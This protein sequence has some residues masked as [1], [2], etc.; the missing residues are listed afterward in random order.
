MP[1]KKNT[2][3]GFWARVLKTDNCWLW[4]GAKQARGYGFVKYHGRQHG[5]HRIAWQL[6]NGPIPDG[7][8]VCHHCDNPQCVRPEHLFIGTTSDNMIDCSRKGRLVDN[9]G[10]NQGRSRLTEIDVVEIRTMDKCGISQREIA[11]KYSVS[12]PL[13]SM[14]LSRKTWRHI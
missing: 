13:I 10:A 2:P 9:S 11:S 8:S 14:I 3:E 7:M 12:Q 1:Q 4:L 6:I 5:A